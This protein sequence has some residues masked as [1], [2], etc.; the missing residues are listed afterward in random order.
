[1]T[2]YRLLTLTLLLSTVVG[3]GPEQV[4]NLVYQ[5]KTATDAGAPKAT[6]GSSFVVDESGLLATNFHVVSTALHEPK[7]YHL[8]L[9]DGAMTTPAEVVAFD[10]ANDLALIKVG[11]TFPR[12]VTFARKMP[13]AGAKIYSIGLPEDLNKAVI[14]GNFNGLMKQGPYEKLQ[15]SIPLNPGMSGGP[16]L[17]ALGE[18]LGVN[19]SI[20]IDSQNLAFGIP[21]DKVLALLKK[22]RRNFSEPDALAAFDEEV[23]DQLDQVQDQLTDLI[24]K[25]STPVTIGDWQVDKPSEGVKCWRDTDNGAKE[26]SVQTNE[27]CYLPGTSPVRNDHDTGTFRIKYSAL[28]STKLNDWQFLSLLNEG[29]EQSMYAMADYL[30]RFTT[31]FTCGEMDLLNAHYVPLRVHYCVSAYVRYSEIYNMEF[32]AVTLGQE[33]SALIVSA[34]L[35]GFTSRSLTAITKRLVN[36]IKHTGPGP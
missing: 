25:G 4:F 19:V 1:M 29:L 2:P 3:A 36:S 35:L 5:I 8:F 7:K 28:G 22:E 21:A 31:R 26:L 16:T 15:M 30:E 23:R 20:R 6:Y 13:E 14:E 34:S 12:A 9:V 24:V 27:N 33:H 18:I 11:R 17:N 10:V 32:E